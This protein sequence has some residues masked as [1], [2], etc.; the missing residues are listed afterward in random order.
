MSDG[1]TVPHA[2]PRR[3]TGGR[4]DRRPG[5]S[6]RVMSSPSTRSSPRWRRR[7]RWSNC[8]ARSP[9]PSSS[10]SRHRARRSPSALRSSRSRLA[11]ASPT[12]RLCV[13]E[14]GHRGSVPVPTGSHPRRLRPGEAVPS[15]RRSSRHRSQ[16][17]EH[18]GAATAE[19][20]CR[21]VPTVTS[22]RT[23]RHRTRAGRPA[24]TTARGPTR[25]LHGATRR[26]RPGG[27]GGA[28]AGR[29]HH[30]RRSGGLSSEPAPERPRRPVTPGTADTAW[31][32]EPMGAGART[33]GTAAPRC[34]GFRSGWRKPWCGASPKRHKRASSCRST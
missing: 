16:R 22:P 27:R 6:R 20:D 23:Q 11:R 5:T 2:G 15:R 17:H 19:S 21:A 26:R 12:P 30:P 24:R 33:A 3:G 25:P 13:D 29:D 10:C 7:R 9:A 1:E 34:A 32:A 28:R 14:R 8:R 18:P 31:T 4:G